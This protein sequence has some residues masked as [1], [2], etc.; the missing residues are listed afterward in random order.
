MSEVARAVVDFDTKDIK[1]EYCIDLH[2]RDR[3]VYETC[4]RVPGR[5]EAYQD[6]DERIAVVCFGPSLEDTWEEVREF[7]YIITCSGAHRFLIDRGIIPTWHIEV[8]P[9][10]HKA[11]LIGQPHRDVEYLVASVCHREV[12]DLLDGFN[13]KLWHVFSDEAGRAS[14][15]HAFPRGEWCITGG[16]HV[17]ARAMTLARFLGFKKQVVFGMDHSFRPGRQHAAE[18]PNET[19]DKWLYDVRIG[20]R[21]FLTSPAMHQYAIK[22]F[23][24]VQKLGRIELEVRGD[25]LLQERIK[26]FMQAGQKLIPEN[27]Q[28][29]AIGAILPL[30]ASPE[31]IELQRQLH[32]ER[33]DYGISGSKRIAVVQ[34]MIEKLKPKSVLD[35]GC[36]K[37]TLAAGLAM[38]IWEYDP[39]IA[40][41]D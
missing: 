22:F 35:Y 10:P 20:E 34:R 3:Q 2:T 5:L 24:E 9:R 6:N 21:L 18:H 36:G 17:G 27:V 14:V 25:G 33:P 37:G 12:F 23:K 8:D 39:A 30:V 38:P 1:T 13:V 15:I 7:K 19:K 16:Q 40:G 26:E 11:K 4:A 32:R 41:K 31:Y 29:A 28:P